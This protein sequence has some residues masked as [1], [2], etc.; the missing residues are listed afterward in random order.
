MMV[1]DKL[2]FKKFKWVIVKMRRNFLTGEQ[3]AWYRVF[4]K[5]RRHGHL[6]NTE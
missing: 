1:G 6:S 3:V 5:Y 4:R 2:Q